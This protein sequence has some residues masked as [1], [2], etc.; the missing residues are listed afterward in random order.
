[1]FLLFQ[2]IAIGLGVMS[3]CSHCQRHEEVRL[4]LCRAVTSAEKELTENKWQVLFC[5]HLYDKLIMYGFQC[6]KHREKNKY[7][8][9]ALVDK[10]LSMY[11]VGNSIPFPFVY[12]LH[13]TED[14]TEIRDFR[15]VC[16]LSTISFSF[17]FPLIFAWDLENTKLKCKINLFFWTI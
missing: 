9:P 5:N 4:A 1:M 11:V 16:D 6:R 2:H 8:L 13:Q 15:C 14:F 3:R 17:I 7:V 12:I 10:A